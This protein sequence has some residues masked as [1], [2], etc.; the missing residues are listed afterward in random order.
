MQAVLLRFRWLWKT[1]WRSGF[2]GI[3]SNR[4]SPHLLCTFHYTPITSSLLIA[5][6]ANTTV[7]TSAD[8]RRLRSLMCGSERGQSQLARMPI[9][10][11][12]ISQG[13]MLYISLTCKWVYVYTY[14]HCVCVCVRICVSG[15]TFVPVFEQ[16]GYVYM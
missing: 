1:F 6:S 3:G 7:L 4:I 5:K 14:I 2:N 12:D 9:I 10:R 13:A 15:C 8:P 11:Q 16:A